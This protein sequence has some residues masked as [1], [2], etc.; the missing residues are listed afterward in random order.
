[1]PSRISFNKFQYRHNFKNSKN[2]I[3]NQKVHCK[4]NSMLPEKEQ[5][6]SDTRHV[7]QQ[8]DGG[9]QH[10]HSDKCF[11]LFRYGFHYPKMECAGYYP[12]EN[13]TRYTKRETICFKNCEKNYLRNGN[14]QNQ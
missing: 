6:N 2:K 10:E 8:F 13:N 1:M 4:R 14:C 3:D 5:V 11:G 7:E 12:H 9:L